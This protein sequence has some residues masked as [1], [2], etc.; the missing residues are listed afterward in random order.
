MPF[1]TVR[2][3]AVSATLILVSAVL[4]WGVTVVAVAV[5]ANR[6]ETLPANAIVVLGAAQYN[7]RPSPVFRARLDHAAALYQR[8][9][10]PVVLVT[11]G[12]GRGDTLSETEVGKSY[13]LQLG[14]P[15]DAVVALAAT[16]STY[17]SL[18]SVADWFG[19]RPERRA[20]F[21]SDGFHML[22]IR[23]IAPRLGVSPLTSP[24]PG[25]PIHANARRNL[26]FMLAEGIKVPLAWLFQR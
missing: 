21:V 12:V 26:S 14:L 17:R 25:S 18:R 9:L 7:G 16:S 23:I 22:R 19:E 4:G 20:L 5:H 11:G 15:S 8:G 24:A 3:A 1:W 6:R 2:R 10:A 13:L